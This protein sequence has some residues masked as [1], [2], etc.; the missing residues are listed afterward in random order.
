MATM[1]RGAR[2]KEA[3]EVSDRVADLFRRPISPKKDSEPAYTRPI[4]DAP[5]TLRYLHK[6]EAIFTFA[7]S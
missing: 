6:F 3:N 2:C 1:L 5:L 4:S 7:L